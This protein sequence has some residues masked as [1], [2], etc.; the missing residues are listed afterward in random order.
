[1]ITKPW[2]QF[3][4]DLDDYL[5]SQGWA[6]RG[7]AIKQRVGDGRIEE[8][9]YAQVILYLTGHCYEIKEATEIVIMLKNER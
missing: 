4:D 6:A 7:A 2:N 9:N 3:L 5:W 8:G 1:M